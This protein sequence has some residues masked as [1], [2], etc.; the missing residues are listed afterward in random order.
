MKRFT[1]WALGIVSTFPLFGCTSSADKSSG[2]A[3]SRPPKGLESVSDDTFFVTTFTAA[4]VLALVPLGI[5]MWA[6]VNGRK[7]GEMWPFTMSGI[8]AGVLFV[9]ALEGPAALAWAPDTIKWVVI[10]LGLLALIGGFVGGLRTGSATPGQGLQEAA[11]A[12]PKG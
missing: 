4:V 7:P 5:R 10:C 1:F 11:P 8:R 6:S 3:P 2:T 9:A 12:K